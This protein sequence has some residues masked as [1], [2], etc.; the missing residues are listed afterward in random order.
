MQS[1][2]DFATFI[3]ILLLFAAIGAVLAIWL[4]KRQPRRPG[5]RWTILQ[6]L[7]GP[8]AAHLACIAGPAKGQRHELRTSQISIG[9][10]P[11]NMIVVQDDWVS[12]QHAMIECRND[13]FVLYDLGSSNGTYVNGQQV[14]QYVLQAGDQV[15]IGPSVFVF[16]P[17]QYTGPVTSK[18][19]RV[20]SQVHPAHVAYDL[21]EYELARRLGEGGAATVY[22][23][24]A[25]R[26]RQTVAIKVLHSGDPYFQLKFRQELEIGKTMIH[27]HITR[28]YGGGQSR[29]QGAWYI[30]MEFN[31]GGD[32]RERLYPERPLPFEEVIRIA[33]QTCDA[34][35]YAHQRGIYHRDMKPENIL[36]SQSGDVK[37]SDFGIA[38]IAT[39]RTITSRG[40]LIGTTEYMSYEQAR[41]HDIDGRSDVYSMGIVLYEMLAGRRPFD[42]EPLAVLEK[43]LSEYPPPPSHINP[44]LPGWVDDVVMTAIEK[45]ISRRFQSTEELAQALGYREPFHGDGYEPDIQASVPDDYAAAQP[46]QAS[47]ACLV[48]QRSGHSI[49]LGSTP[50]LLGQEGINP[51][52]N[53]MCISRQHA[54]IVWNGAYWIED[55]NSTNGTFVNG[56]RI[57][58]GQ[59]TM[60]QP[61]DVITLGYTQMRFET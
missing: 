19:V 9:R 7:S 20:A 28:I 15:Q 54:R 4:I 36:F 60:L 50:V 26:D 24:H 35:Y 53:D 51:D 18:P 43:H 44:S 14:S 42:G 16:T 1:S 29:D 23:G 5:E 27:P 57:W 46:S 10:T 3:L 6:R 32:L 17:P 12:R 33:G 61:G 49:A 47:G 30:V 22:Q 39:R 21:G 59:P 34:L 37:L 52:L 13:Q 2:N 38:R 8:T 48:D 56:A 25:R 40:V 31:A 41:G 45:D 55:M 58:P 11:E